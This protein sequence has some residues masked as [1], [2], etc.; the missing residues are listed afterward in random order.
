MSAVPIFN[1]TMK[2]GQFVPDDRLSFAQWCRSFKDGT[3]VT[4]EIKRHQKRKS[5]NQ[6][7]YYRGHVCKVLGDHLGYTTDEMHGIIQAR[8]FVYENPS[9]V[10]YVRSTALDGW[11]TKEWEDKMEEIIRWAAEEFDV[12]ILRPDE[13]SMLDYYEAY[14]V[15]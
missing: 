8:F 12:V 13:V 9:G 6:N 4:F 1:G 3:R 7:R 5:N 15:S 14:H 2:G 11:S 10:R